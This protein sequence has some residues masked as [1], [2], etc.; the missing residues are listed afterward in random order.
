MAAG[1]PEWA[2]RRDRE[3]NG[4]PMPDGL[5][6]ELKAAAIAA[7]VHFEEERGTEPLA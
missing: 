2:K 7:D 1:G 4:I 3:A 5:Y 6:T